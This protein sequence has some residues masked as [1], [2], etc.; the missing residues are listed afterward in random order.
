MYS[1]SAHQTFWCW[2]HSTKLHC[3][4]LPQ[5]SF[6]SCYT[7]NPITYIFNQP[8]V[9]SLLFHQTLHL[10]VLNHL[11]IKA[12]LFAATLQLLFNSIYSVVINFTKLE[13]S[14]TV[15]MN[16]T[17]HGTGIMQEQVKW[18]TWNTHLYLQMKSV[19]WIL[20]SQKYCYFKP[21]KAK[22]LPII[23]TMVEAFLPD[24]LLQLTVN[25]LQYQDWYC[26]KCLG[27]V[28]NSKHFTVRG[29]WLC[30]N[31]YIW[32]Y[33]VGHIS[34]CPSPNTALRDNETF[35]YECVVI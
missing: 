25:T 5:I 23:W 19:G 14:F 1:H 33:S 3:F 20:S 28:S 12:P 21:P 32:I 30:C 8:L 35:P 26:T 9:M 27:S 17:S 7:T 16:K 6:F 24:T 11:Y 15:V 34:A 22:G 10:F 13:T 31:I 2:G 4:H 18:I 29:T